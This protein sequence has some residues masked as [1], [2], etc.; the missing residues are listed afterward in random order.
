M[1]PQRED[2]LRVIRESG[3]ALP[4]DFDDDTSL[5]RSGLV[6]STA[7]FDV[8]LW[9]EERIAPGIDLTDLDLTEEWDT[10]RKLLAFVA[11][12]GRAG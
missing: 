2:L 8:V 9:V 11:R 10:V 3:V 1:E 5:I 12:H 7:L 4:P 6:D